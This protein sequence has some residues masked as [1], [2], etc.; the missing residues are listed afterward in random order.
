MSRKVGR[1]AAVQGKSRFLYRNRS[2][3]CIVDTDLDCVS[4]SP[5]VCFTAS[6]IAKAIMAATIS[7]ATIKRVNYWLRLLK[8]KFYCTESMLAVLSL[9]LSKFQDEKPK[10]LRR[11]KDCE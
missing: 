6:V 8:T 4:S 2:I 7:P 1:K 10:Y 11:P 3:R 9:I 5:A